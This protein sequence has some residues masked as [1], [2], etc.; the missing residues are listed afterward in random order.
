MKNLWQKEEIYKVVLYATEAFNRKYQIYDENRKVFTAHFTLVALNALNFSMEED[1]DREFL[2]KVA[3]LHDVIEDT[4]VTYED[5]VKEFGKKVADG[6][7][8]LSRDEKIEY[9]KQI[10]ECIERIK[11]Q[12]KEVAIVKMADRLYNIREPF[13]TW[14]KEKIAKYKIESQFICDELGYAC[15]NLKNELQTAIDNYC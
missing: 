12:P 13:I 10:P 3:I 15:E 2:M 14:S 5:L 9:E 6:V 1:V 8:S 11:R 7:L 4:D